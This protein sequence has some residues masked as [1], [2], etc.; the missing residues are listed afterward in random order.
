MIIYMQFADTQNKTYKKRLRSL[1]LSSHVAKLFASEQLL[2]TWVWLHVRMSTVA[3]VELYTK[4]AATI[5]PCHV[6]SF[7]MSNV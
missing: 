2:V 7:Q 5:M 6:T 4:I 1:M 3:T